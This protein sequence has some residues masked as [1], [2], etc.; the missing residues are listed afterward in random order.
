M[1]FFEE[2]CT[3]Q[4][5]ALRA[6]S[7]RGMTNIISRG[8][9]TPFK[10]LILGLMAKL[11]ASSNIDKKLAVAKLMP[12]VAELCKSNDDLFKN[13]SRSYSDP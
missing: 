8:G 4:E 7:I 1:W 3:F 13:V 2:S 10:V 6:Q 12:R 9:P 5:R 11:R